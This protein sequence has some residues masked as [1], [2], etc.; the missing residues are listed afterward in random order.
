MANLDAHSEAAY[1]RSTNARDEATL[2]V[3]LNAH[4][5]VIYK[6]PAITRTEAMLERV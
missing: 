2:A 5:E 6:H 3:E 1:E 4:S